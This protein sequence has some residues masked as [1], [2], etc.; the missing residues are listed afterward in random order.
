MEEAL[1]RK[2]AILLRGGAVQLPAGFQVPFRISRST[3]GPGAG[4]RSIV[5]NF[6]GLRVKKAIVYDEADFQL[7]EREGG[8]SLLHHGQ[9]FL[10]EVEIGPVVFHAPEQAFFNLDQR[11]IFHCLYCS[12]PLLGPDATKG[13]DAEKIVSLTR[14]AMEKTEVGALALTSGV[15]GSVQE[16]VD[17]MVE[18]VRLARKEIPDLPIGVEPYVLER[19]QIVALRKAGADEIKINLESPDPEIF[20]STCPELDQ[21]HVW[22]MLEI[23]V[24]VFGRGKVASNII[25]GMGESDEIVLAAAERMASLGVVPGLRVLTLNESNR[26]HVEAELGPIEAPSIERML[27][28]AR[29]HK[30]ILAAHDLDPREVKSMCFA[31]TCCDL[32]PYRDL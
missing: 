29:E 23:A 4:K 7:I 25:Y 20:R 30:R 21:E 12:S 3:A 5:F 18:C 2:K 8:F 27:H 9:P 19:E 31:C 16:T 15:H 11:C 6:H 22:R 28:L 32:V 24:E 10:D 13:L 14:E 17:R 26:P 1:T